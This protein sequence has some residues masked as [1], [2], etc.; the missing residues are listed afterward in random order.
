DKFGGNEARARRFIGNMNNMIVGATQDP[1]TMKLIIDKLGE[2]AITVRSSSSGIGS[3]TE[4]AGL[5]FSSN[6]SD[7][8]E[9]VVMEIFPKSLLP[10]LPDLHYIG[11]FNRGEL[12]K[13]RIPVILEDAKV[14]KQ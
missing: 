8:A 11:I 9:D 4:D 1:D 2:T 3:K 5:E 14:K 7:K 12:I 10:S 13:G 6:Q